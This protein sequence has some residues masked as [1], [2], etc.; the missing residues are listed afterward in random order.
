MLSNPGNLLKLFARHLSVWTVTSFKCKKCIFC[1][2]S[3][4]RS[5]RTPKKGQNLHKDTSRNTTIKIPSEQNLL[6]ATTHSIVTHWV[7]AWFIGVEITGNF[8]GLLW[9][10]RA[11]V[12]SQSWVRLLGCIRLIVKSYI[13]FGYA[14]VRPGPARCLIH[15]QIK[16]LIC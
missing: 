10:I 15:S 1:V 13:V 12:Y 5:V 7:T 9:T 8:T 16:P 4:F 14:C 3:W 6:Y 11:S 2:R